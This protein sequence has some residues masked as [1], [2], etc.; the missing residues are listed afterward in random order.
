MESENVGFPHAF[1]HVTLVWLEGFQLG[2]EEAPTSLVIVQPLVL[3][4]R[5]GTRWKSDEFFLTGSPGFFGTG[6]FFLQ[7][8]QA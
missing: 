8:V 6:Y 2:K 5:L 7:Q 1:G 3:V 4:A